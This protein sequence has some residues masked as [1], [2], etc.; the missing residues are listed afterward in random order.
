MLRA[1][2]PPVWALAGG[3]YA[4]IQFGPLN[5]WTNNYW[6]GAVSA[7]A[8]CLVFGALP[9]LWRSGRA[10]D[11]ALVGLGCGL[12]ILTRPFESVMLAVCIAVPIGIVLGRSRRNFAVLLL[13]LSPALALTLLQN[14]AVTG[15]WTTL[16]YM[17]SRYQY[18]VPATFTF[19]PNAIA[20]NELT[21]EQQLDLQAQTDVHGDTPETLA[22]FCKRLADRVRFF[23]FFFLPPLFV[24][25]PFFLPALRQ[26]RYLWAAGSV[27]IFQLGS[28]CYPYYYAHY[29]AA[30]TCLLFLF[31]VEGLERLSRIRLRGFAVGGDAMRILASFCIAHFAFWYGLHLVGTEDL[32]IA[33]GSYESWD[34]VNF[35]DAEGRIAINRRLASAPGD[36]LV[37]VRFGPKHLLREWIHN[38]ADIDRSRVAWALDLGPEEDAKLIAYYP[39]RSVWLVEPDATPPRL[40]PWSLETQK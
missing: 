10:R 21:R 30:V 15:S 25:L 28:N 7:I 1:W 16:P 18:G 34:F 9:R 14:E 3:F 20:H 11:A 22:S 26:R 8:G 12:Q 40:T 2:V 31:A 6:G 39:K 33:T 38:D 27:V 19:Q 24:A 4:V 36:Q 35:G 37:I 29:I 32:F 17:L 5:Q 13:A 23:R